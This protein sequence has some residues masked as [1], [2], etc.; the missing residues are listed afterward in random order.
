MS[1][2]HQAQVAASVLASTLT[3]WRGTRALT[4]VKP[5]A[6]PLILFDIEA[7]PHCRAVRQALTALR[8]DVL[9]QP[10]PKGGQRFRG[11]AQALSAKT[12]FPLLVDP[13]TG[14]TLQESA[15]IVDY[16]F[17]T[18]GQGAAP[19]RLRP[20][21]WMASLGSL[22]SASR[23]LRGLS[24]RPAKV[25][26]QPL[27]LWSFESSPYS[28][29]VRERLCELELPYVLHNLGKEQFADM[30]PARLRV[31]PGPYKPLPDGPRAAMLRRVGRV[32]VPYLEDPN[33]GSKLFESEDILAYLERQYA[34]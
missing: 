16:L 11:Q 12:Q 9:I 5:A 3:G 19:Q 28:R 23:G 27:H 25:A 26:A 31:R 20:S 13:N 34:L 2:R 1:L 18:Y 24:A 15:A 6:Q 22:A 33:T 21:R 14:K 10:C 30:G 7:C 29:L 32:Q 4:D 17:A 8:L